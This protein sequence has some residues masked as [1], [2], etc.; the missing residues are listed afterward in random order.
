[1]KR[2]NLYTSSF[3][4][5][6]IAIL[7]SLNTPFKIQA[8]LLDLPYSAEERYRSP[9]SVIRDRTAHCFDGAL[10]AAAALRYIGYPPIIVD[11]LPN[12]RD[13]DHLIAPYRVKR[14]WG[15][16]AKS[17]FSGLTFREPVYRDLREL[18]M[19]YFENFYNVN[20][21]KTLRAYT[22][23]LNLAVFDPL[24]WMS[25]DEHLDLISQRLDRIRSF[26][27]LSPSMQRRLSPVDERAYQAG[28][29]GANWEGLYKP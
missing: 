12:D 5:G 26:K 1:M 17:N 3:G 24:H 21:E 20:R 13:D 18:V 2:I 25:N 4:A 10:F 27:L 29:L 22:V 8:F 14:S 9:C 7:D 19:S 23:P 11:L 6:E 28:L 15:A 16:V